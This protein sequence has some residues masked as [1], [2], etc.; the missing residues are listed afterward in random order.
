[1]IN[2]VQNIFVSHCLVFALQG[3]MSEEDVT[4]GTV[5]PVWGNL[6]RLFKMKGCYVPPVQHIVSNKH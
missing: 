4:P 5:Y 2:F 1:M 3:P 6:R